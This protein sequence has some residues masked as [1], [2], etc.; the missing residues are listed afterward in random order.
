MSDANRTAVGLVEEVTPGTTPVTPVFENLRIKGES[1][2]Y[3]KSTTISAELRSDAQVTDVITTGFDAGGSIPMEASF[4]ALDAILRGVMRSDFTWMPVRENIAGQTTN[5]GAVAAT[6]Y[7]VIA[8]DGTRYRATAFAPLHLVRASG[9]TNAAN[10]KQ[11]VAGAGTTATSIVHTGGIVEA[12]PP[13]G[14][15]LKAIGF[16]GAAGDIVATAGGLTSTA[17][18]FITMGI[19]VGMWIWVGGAAA[20]QKYATAAN[21]GWARVT[22]VAAGALGLDNLPAGW[23]ADAGAGKTIRVFFGDVIRNGTTK[24][25]F[26][27]EVQL[28]DV[29]IFDYFTGMMA[30]SLE[31]GL[32]ARSLVD[33]TVGWLGRSMTSLVS[34]IAGAT[35]ILAPIFDVLNTSS[36]VGQIFENGAVIPGAN[37]VMSAGISIKNNLRRRNALGTLASVDIVPGRFVVDGSLGTYFGDNTIRNKI[38]NS[39]ASSVMFVLSDGTGPRGYLFDMP[40]VKFLEGDPQSGGVDTDRTLSPRY[41]A[42]RSPTFG[43]TLHV[44]RV[45]EYAT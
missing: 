10:N 14:A 5:V 34:R 7:A 16:E 37:F 24:R 30:D 32:A 31:F 33:V 28:Q 19:I 20:G 4:G 38:L 9:F 42:L 6:T 29:S 25:T 35:D 8:S 18:N 36:N 12:V 21:F 11:F 17:T 3:R 44:Q 40:R 43:Y 26:S 2:E 41:Q 13:I 22:S 1:L 15:R 23:G 27:L 45:E 39:V